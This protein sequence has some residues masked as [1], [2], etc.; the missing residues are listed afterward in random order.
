MSA[1][2][3]I[4]PDDF[5]RFSE[6]F[7]RKTG[8][9]FDDSKR[10]FVDRRL[11]DR[12]S[13][14][15]SQ[16]FNTYFRLLRLNPSGS[17]TQVLTNLMTVNETYFFREAYQFE[18]LTDFIL[19]EVVRYKRAGDPIRIWSMPCSSGEEPYS[20]AIHLMEKWAHIDR[21]DVEIFGSDIDT[22]IL[23]SAQT[24][25]YSPR[26]VQGVPPNQMKKYFTKLR[27]GN[28]QICQ[29]LRDSVEFVRTNLNEPA[30]LARFSRV[31]VIFCRN[32]LIYFDDMSR[33]AAAEAFYETMSPGAFICLG[34]SESMS[35]ISSLF[36]VRRFGSTIVYQKPLPGE[37]SA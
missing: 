11:T 7:Y 9:H 36:K 13:A 18:C 33:R 28:W 21:Y 30:D 16:D 35:R 27:D 29:D 1:V 8:I 37:A 24:G 31:D 23:A 4:T 17:E 22:T 32:L 25:I 34:H 19:A 26:S 3:A 14:T 12:I 20:I 6:Y 2:K 10:Y 15:D 5:A